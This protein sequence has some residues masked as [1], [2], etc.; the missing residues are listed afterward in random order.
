[1]NAGPTTA[2]QKFV[3]VGI[4]LTGMIALLAKSAET[5]GQ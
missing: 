3:V 1:M 2:A 5:R 4:L